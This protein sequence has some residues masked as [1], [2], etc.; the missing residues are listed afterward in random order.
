[1]SILSVVRLHHTDA[2]GVIFCSRLLELAHEAYEALLDE[3]GLSVGRDPG[4]GGD[5]AVAATSAREASARV[6][7]G[8][9]RLPVVQSPEYF[10]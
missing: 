4:G 3:A 8:L 10:W 9:L 6:L 5:G 2:A 1:M 7:A